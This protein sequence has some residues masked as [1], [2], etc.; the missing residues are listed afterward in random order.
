MKMFL[1]FAA[2]GLVI[3][4][5]AFAQGM[6]AADY[7]KNAG[8]SDLFERQSSQ[9]VLQ[10]TTDPKVKSFANMMISAHAKSTA[11]VKAAAARSKVRVAPPVLTPAQRDMIA[12]LRE[13]KGTARDTTYIQQQKTAHDQ[14]LA[15]QQSYASD[16]KSAPL[17]AVAAKIVP[18]VQDHIRMLATM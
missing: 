11:D 14:A 10:S 4:A 5:P 15:L 17:K 16:G 9:I 13:Q 8:A 3:A 7:V 1:P 2:V 18:V 6:P 12:K